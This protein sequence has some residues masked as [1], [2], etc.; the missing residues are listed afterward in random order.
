MTDTPTETPTNTP[1]DTP[2]E[3]PT[4]TPTDDSTPTNTPTST[5]T[6]TP[7]AYAVHI[8][9]TTPPIGSVFQPNQLDSLLVTSG[10]AIQGSTFGVSY[11]ALLYDQSGVLATSSASPVVTKSGTM[12][13]SVSAVMPNSGTVVLK[14]AL[15]TSAW[16][17]L[18]QDS[19][20][21]SI[22]TPTP[23]PTEWYTMQITSTEPD[24]SQPLT[25]WRLYS[26]R[27]RTDY[28]II[29]PESGARIH[30][31]LWT[32]SGLLK[33][34]AAVFMAAS[35]NLRNYE[36][37]LSSVIPDDGP[38]I[39]KMRILD[40]NFDIVAEDSRTFAV[41][42]PTPTNTPT[43]TNTPVPTPTWPASGLTNDE[44]DGYQ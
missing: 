11:A 24:I 7:L 15:V 28:R 17:I 8:L 43:A 32:T 27:V 2:T 18:A 14:A 5:P 3:T 31:S 33:Q 23:T 36:T 44:W 35:P 29:T 37:T 4:E 26:I 38:V 34:N 42:T 21:Y 22:A 12:T 10:Y 19:R 39:L 41:A 20:V 25:T 40:E 30:A 9:E 16:D 13:V 6:S 1:S